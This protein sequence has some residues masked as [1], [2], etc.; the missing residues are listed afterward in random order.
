[1]KTED[2]CAHFFKKAAVKVLNAFLHSVTLQARRASYRG[3]QPRP[4]T[5]VAFGVKV[6]GVLP[7]V[8]DHK[9]LKKPEQPPCKDVNG[10][11]PLL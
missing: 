1:L 9:V 10:F 5:Q 8:H 11:K 7:N 3:I 4:P 6:L 2:I